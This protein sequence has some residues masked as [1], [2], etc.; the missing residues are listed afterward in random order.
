MASDDL[1][2]DKIYTTKEYTIWA[3]YHEWRS[4][5]HEGFRLA[6]SYKDHFFM[7]DTHE[8]KKKV[9]PI[10]K[11]IA[12][13]MAKLDEEARQLVTTHLD[14]DIDFDELMYRAWIANRYWDHL[15]NSGHE[16]I[17]Q[18]VQQER[19]EQVKKKKRVL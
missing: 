6:C 10:Y 13:M 5:N 8:L 19:E 11:R 14:K 1:V 16:M 17:N 4:Q 9:H 2:L 15:Q 3:V 18:F 7:W 12:S